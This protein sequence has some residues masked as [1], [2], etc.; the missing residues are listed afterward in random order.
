MYLRIW[1]AIFCVM[2]SI[3]VAA[4]GADT[5]AKAP[6]LPIVDVVTL[7][8]KTV[9]GRLA[10]ADVVEVKIEPTTAGQEA[11][12]IPWKNVRR[13]SNGLTQAKA[14]EAWKTLHK[15]ELCPTCKGERFLVCATCKGTF[16][17][18]KQYNNAFESGP[19]E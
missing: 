1:V 15:D 11:Q 12:T 3:V 4:T 9:H 13:V 19:P 2:F 16:N 8:G 5:G 14:A 10:S 6:V 17:P 18:D 7:D